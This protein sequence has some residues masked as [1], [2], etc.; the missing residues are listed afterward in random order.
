MKKVVLFFS[1]FPILCFTHIITYWVDPI[2][3]SYGFYIDQNIEF[4][5]IKALLHYDLKVNWEQGFPV[6]LPKEPDIFF[7]LFSEYYSVE[8]GYFHRDIPFSVSVNPYEIGLNVRYGFAGFYNDLNYFSGN[9]VDLMFKENFI[10]IGVKY[11][12]LKIFFEKS[13]EQH[14]FGIQLKNVICFYEDYGVKIA[15]YFQGDSFGFYFNPMYEKIGFVLLD[16]EN[17]LFVNQDEIFS[18]VKWGDLDVFGRFQKEEK[19][20]SIGFKVW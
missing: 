8:Y 14:I 10:N 6:V 12:F 7:Y 2:N 4:W 15:L 9:V 18:S 11:K 16:G 1:L 13:F 17:Y 20:F 3:F 5:K 19:R